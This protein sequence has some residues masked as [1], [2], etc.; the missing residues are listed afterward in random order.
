VKVE[1]SQ[2]KLLLTGKIL[3]FRENAYSSF[4]F[5]LCEIRLSYNPTSGR[6]RHHKKPLKGTGLRDGIQIFWQ[7]WILLGQNMNLYRFLNFW[8]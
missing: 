4:L 7:K 2:Y 1:L 5:W 6:Q 3:Y 8:N